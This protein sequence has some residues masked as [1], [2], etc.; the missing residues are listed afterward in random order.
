MDRRYID[1]CGSSVTSRRLCREPKVQ[2]SV[3]TRDANPGHQARGREDRLEPE[4]RTTR[5]VSFSLSSLCCIPMSVSLKTQVML[6]GRAAHRCAFPDCRLILVADATETDDESL[7]GEVCHIVGQSPGGPRGETDLSAEKRDKYSNLILLCRNHHKVI[8]DQEITYTIDRLHEMKNAH[9]A[10][11][12]DS[13]QGY[14]ASRQRDNEL[15]ASYIDEFVKRAN[16]DN[17]KGWSGGLFSAGYQHIDKEMYEH[18]TDLRNWIFSRIWPHRLTELELPHLKTSGTSCRTC[19]LPSMKNRR[20]CM[21]TFCTRR[22][23]I[24]YASGMKIVITTCSS[25]YEYHVELVEDLMV[26]LTRAANYLCDIVRKHLDPTFRLAQGALIIDLGMCMDMKW[27]SIRAEYRRE[28]RGERPY[29]GLEVF[30]ETRVTRDF[31]AGS[32]YGPDGK[33]EAAL[34][35][36]R[37]RGMMVHQATDGVLPYTSSIQ[38]VCIDSDTDLA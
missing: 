35:C 28:E 15:Y 29:P 37:G 23:S 1:R 8:D 25:R 33:G 22:N 18:L 13:L 4:T 11:V 7:I 5:L 3:Q 14:D 12:S 21:T 6:W 17:W 2:V 26:E 30:K 10:W 27:H 19:K 34:G 16:L 38:G 20:F 36:I 24:R 31:H 32:G 9:E